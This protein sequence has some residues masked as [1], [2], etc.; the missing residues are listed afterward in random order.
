MMDDEMIAGLPEQEL[1]AQGH[2]A[3]AGCGC[4]AALRHGLKAAGRDVIVVSA[5]GCMEVVSSAYPSSSWRV[6]WIH[7]NFENAAAVASGI[8]ASLKKA[9]SKTKVLVFA[10][11]GGTFDI[12]LQALSGAVERNTDFVYVCYDNGAYMNTGI[13][14]SGAT[15][16][17]AATTTS[18]AGKVIHGKVEWKK[19]M[20]FIVAGHGDFVYVATANMAFPQDYF[21]KVKKALEHKG[22]AYIQIF[23]PCVPGWKIAAN[24][25]VDVAKKAFLS[26]ITPLYEIE[27][28]VLRFTKKVDNPIPVQDCLLMQ[29]RFK[30]LNDKE[31]E[32]IQQRVD[33]EYDRLLKI[34]ASGLKVF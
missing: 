11:D 26:K 22:P 4:T 29:G 27:N 16:R 9:K 23:S 34:E 5:T 1:F 7:A 19:Q 33:S 21:L 24:A 17:Y 31:I 25:T 14:R 30:H 10:G 12:G 6:P 8:V 18:P 15:P 32:E 28:G 13:Q 2:L 3:C 20:P